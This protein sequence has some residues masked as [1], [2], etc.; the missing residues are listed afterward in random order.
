MKCYGRAA[1][2][3]FLGDQIVFRN[4]IPCD[5]RLPELAELRRTLNFPPNFLPRKSMPEYGRVLSEIVRAA[6][7]LTLPK[8]AIQRVIYVGDTRMNDGQAFLNIC[9]AGSWQGMAFIGSDRPHPLKVELEQQGQQTLYIATRWKAIEQFDSYLSDNHFSVDEHTA[10]LFDLDKTLLG[11]RGRNDRVI[12]AKRLSAAEDTLRE[13]LDQDY[14]PA[15]FQEAY[16]ALNQAEFHPFTADNQ[17]YLVYICLIISSGLVTLPDLITA[18]RAGKHPQFQDF[19]NFVEERAGALPHQVRDIHDGVISRVQSG[20]PTP[21]KTFRHN[22]F[23]H[24]VE[25]M[26]HL[27]DTHPVEQLLA[28]E[29]VVTA[30]IYHLA[31]HWKEQGALLFGLSDKPDEAT[32]PGQELR[33]QGYLPVHKVATH[34]IGEE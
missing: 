12:D 8:G 17:D 26:G 10:I 25:H 5:H 31:G 32:L 29:I 1:L 34:V 3:D 4:L 23:K 20:D 21:F 9:R 28:E 27:A 11:G 33:D 22:E 24:T 13:A 7:R 18:V 30:E 16:H 2:S 14:N 19:L 15:L 6:R